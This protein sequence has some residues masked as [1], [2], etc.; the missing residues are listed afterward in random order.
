MA[1][2]YFVWR[3]T[4][5]VFGIGDI[6]AAPLNAHDDRNL[7]ER[8]GTASPSFARDQQPKLAS[9]DEARTLSVVWDDQCT[10]WTPWIDVGGES[11]DLSHR[12]SPLEGPLTCLSQAKHM[13]RFGGDPDP[14]LSREAHLAQRVDRPRAALLESCSAPGGRHTVNSTEWRRA[15]LEVVSGRIQSICDAHRMTSHVATRASS[16]RSQALQT[17]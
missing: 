12:D 16:R 6:D 2:S 14:V 5:T 7:R 10:L 8:F 4:A 11:R 1:S 15:V 17:Q 3:C 13:P 9:S